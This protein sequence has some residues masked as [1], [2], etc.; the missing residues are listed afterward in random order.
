MLD[1]K[2]YGAFI[3][4]T[5]RPMIEEAQTL[6]SDLYGY[7]LHLD[8]EDILKIGKF[9]AD[10]HIKVVIIQSVTSIIIC[11]VVCLTLWK[12]PQLLSLS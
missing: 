2:P 7:G 3:E 10:R 9:I 5:I 1:L 4:N 6:L 8:K 12:M 11:G